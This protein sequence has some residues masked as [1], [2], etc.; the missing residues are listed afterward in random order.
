MR[1][2]GVEITIVG[3]YDLHDELNMEDADA[4]DQVD[5]TSHDYAEW[6]ELNHETGEETTWGTFLPPKQHWW[7]R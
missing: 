7:Q 3:S 4:R 2:F 6:E 1:I 5:R